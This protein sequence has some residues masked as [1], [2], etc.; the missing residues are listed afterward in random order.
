MDA[1]WWYFGPALF[2]LLLAPLWAR[3]IGD[4]WSEALWWC[5]VWPVG[6]MWPLMLPGMIF[7]IIDGPYQPKHKVEYR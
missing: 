7:D 2:T 3:R 5:V 6:L 4:P 1:A